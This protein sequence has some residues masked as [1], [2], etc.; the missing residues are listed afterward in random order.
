MSD[1]TP[2]PRSGQDQCFRHIS[3]FRR[4]DVTTYASAGAF[5]QVLFR[6]SDTG[7]YVRTVTMPPGFQSGDR[8]LQHDDFDEIVYVLEGAWHNLTNDTVYPV[9]TVAVFPAGQEHGPFRYPDGA[10]FLE[11]RYYKGSD[12]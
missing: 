7:T 5:E 9:G 10:T 11:L 12:V 3:E 2:S 4:D 8:P 6:A 1:A